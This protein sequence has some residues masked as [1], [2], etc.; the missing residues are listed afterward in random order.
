MNTS[1]ASDS[2]SLLTA[3]RSV[4]NNYTRNYLKCTWALLTTTFTIWTN[5][6]GIRNGTHSPI[7]GRSGFSLFFL[8]SITA[9]STCK[10]TAPLR[11]T[12]QETKWNALGQHYMKNTLTPWTNK[13]RTRNRTHSYIY[14]RIGSWPRQ[15]H[16]KPI[17]YG[18]LSFNNG[19]SLHLPWKDWDTQ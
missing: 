18:L 16:D 19:A 8:P 15:K 6:I 17:H 2:P 7:S 1:L 9:H 5:K 10:Q 13:T 11:I 14:C 12:A 3:S 4:A